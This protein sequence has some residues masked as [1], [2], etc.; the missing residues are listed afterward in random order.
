MP[1]KDLHPKIYLRASVI[2]IHGKYLGK[3]FCRDN[4][5][6]FYYILRKT[7]YN[8]ESSKETATLI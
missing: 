8:L 2:L 6:N 7:A 1:P 4:L 3:I 5:L